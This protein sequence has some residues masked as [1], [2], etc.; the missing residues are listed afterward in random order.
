MGLWT[1]QE[2][3]ALRRAFPHLPEK[4]KVMPEEASQKNP[5]IKEMAVQMYRHLP[6]WMKEKRS[7]DAIKLR[8]MI[9]WYG[10]VVEQVQQ[11]TDA[12]QVLR[13]Q[14]A[15]VSL[16]N[17]R[18]VSENR[19]L[20]SENGKLVSENGTL[21]E[22]MVV[23]QTQVNEANAKVE[24]ITDEMGIAQEE[25]ESAKQDAARTVHLTDEGARNLGHCMIHMY[26]S[27]QKVETNGVTTGV[28]RQPAL[29]RAA[30][31][32]PPAPGDIGSAWN[33]PIQVLPARAV[34]T[35]SSSS[36]PIGA[37]CDGTYS[38]TPVK[39]RRLTLM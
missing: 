24:H 2:D 4:M 34:A 32:E 9:C 19:K 25:A 22:S 14:N 31:A 18:L 36:F 15:R 35:T 20:V 17:G 27:I 12:N 10:I 3:A 23:L 33:L 28:F 7:V 37:A 5:H 11:L 39:R 13:S 6:R 21:V 26:A 1:N 16:A 38:E 8:M 30:N 29:E